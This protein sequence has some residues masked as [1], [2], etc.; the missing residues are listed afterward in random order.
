MVIVDLDERKKERD[1]VIKIDV[2]RYEKNIDEIAENLVKVVRSKKGRYITVKPGTLTSNRRV[3][4]EVMVAL[5]KNSLVDVWSRSRSN[6]RVK[7]GIPEKIVIGD[8]EYSNPLYEIPKNVSPDV[9]KRM[10]KRIIVDIVK[11][12][13]NVVSIVKDYNKGK[14][15]IDIE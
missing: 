10:V 8:K 15:R 6:N 14:I 12:N 9:A 13:G 3:A 1:I 2:D 7:Y 5:N 11:M 4:G